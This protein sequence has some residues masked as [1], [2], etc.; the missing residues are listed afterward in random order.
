MD[1][2]IT[3]EHHRCLGYIEHGWIHMLFGLPSKTYQ[4]YMKAACACKV[5]DA[6]LKFRDHCII[7]ACRLGIDRPHKSFPATLRSSFPCNTH[8]QT[9]TFTSCHSFHHSDN[10]SYSPHTFRHN[11]VNMP[12][13]P[14]S[15]NSQSYCCCHSLGSWALV[16]HWRCPQH[17][18][19]SL[20]LLLQ[21]AA[22]TAAPHLQTQ[23]GSLSCEFHRRADSFG[24]R[25][26]GAC[27]W[28]NQPHRPRSR[29]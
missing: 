4:N 7:K 14:H 15:S 8:T 29:L 2:F 16:A 13:A 19:E 23:A 17:R 11:Q 26:P 20:H 3:A 1:S 27:S 22:M 12:A 21:E 10:T 9:S 25:A 5:V 18:P 6:E 24:S 28:P